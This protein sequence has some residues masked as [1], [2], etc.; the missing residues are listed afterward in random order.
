M[1]EKRDDHEVLLGYAV[2]LPGDRADRGT[3]PVWFS[4]SKLAYDLSLP[5]IRERFDLPAGTVDWT[6]AETLIREAATL[7]GAAGRL[8]GAGDVAALGDLLAV[9]A[10]HSP[11]LVRDHLTAAAAVF[12]QT[13]RA[14]GARTL[15]GRARAG[16]RSP[17]APC[18]KPPAPHTQ[19][20][21]RRSSCNCCW[22]SSRR[23]RPP[24]GGTRRPSTARRHARPPPTPPCCCARR[25]PCRRTDHQQPRTT[26]RTT[27]RSTVETTA[28]TAA[29]T[30]AR[31]T[32]RATSK[33][34]GRGPAPSPP[35]PRPLPGCPR[36]PA[37]TGRPRPATADSKGTPAS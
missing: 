10:T 37:R 8:E 18:N 26:P 6:T 2:A 13:A 15:E 12:E 5:R 31:T 30:A 19:A 24:A 35:L 36:V 34:V 33:P 17:P 14:P 1:H 16:W 32:A 20:E 28:N 4:G 11:A 22:R 29:K 21:A 7:L 27:T 3:R 23:S 25:P 9:A